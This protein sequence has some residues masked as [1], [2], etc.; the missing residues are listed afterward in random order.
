MVFII[1]GNIETFSELYSSWNKSRLRFGI[2]FI[3]IYP[4]IKTRVS[5]VIKALSPTSA[6]RS[7]ER[8]FPE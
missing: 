1:D 5:T 8:G 4:M 7:R 2:P 3:R 6:A